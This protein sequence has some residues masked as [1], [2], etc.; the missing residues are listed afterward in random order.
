MGEWGGRVVADLVIDGESLVAMLID[1]GHGRAYDG[2]RR[3][4]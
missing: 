1:A 2:G 3:G 4:S